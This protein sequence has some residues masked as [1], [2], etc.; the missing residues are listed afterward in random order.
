[1]VQ[2]IVTSPHGPQALSKQHW[3]NFDAARLAA[4]LGEPARTALGAPIHIVEGGSA[5]AGAL[6]LQL[7]ERPRVLIDGRLDRSPWLSE[8]M[9]LH[10]GRLELIEGANVDGAAPVGPDFPQLSWRVVPRDTSATC[11]L[12]H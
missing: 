2:N 4:Q 3:R 6:A 11:P 5:K 12:D 9:V 1:M 10:C 7:S 8:A